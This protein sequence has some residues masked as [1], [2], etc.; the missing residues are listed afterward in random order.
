[1]SD[2]MVR[3]IAADSQVRAFAVTSRDVAETA[4]QDHNSSPEV[5]AALGRTMS[6]ALMM[7]FMM[8]DDDDELTIQLIGDGPM[9]SIT[10]T[11]DPL[12]H[13]KGFAG[14]P[15]VT[16]PA[17]NGKLNVGGAIGSGYLRVIKDVGMKEPYVGTV[18]LQTGEIA[19]DLTYY[20][21]AS[22]QTPSSVGLGVLMNKENT[23]RQAGG[24]IIQLMPDTDDSVIDRLEGNISHIPSVTTM[25]DDGMTPEDILKRV[26]DGFDVEF[27]DK[28]DVSF[29]CDCSRERVENSLVSLGKEDIQSIVADNEPIEVRCQFCNKAYTFTPEEVLAL[30]KK[31]EQK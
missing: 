31:K 22:E 29:Q 16:L 23:V 26:L 5:T 10:V 27:T 4:R 28:K 6:A 1:M 19:D 7:G 17:R 24:F 3:A 11:A 13:V 25:L 30:Q 18:D 14:N 9:R 20:F 8:D 21:A 2:Y 12:G 15:L